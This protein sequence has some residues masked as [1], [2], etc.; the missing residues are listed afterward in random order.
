MIAPQAAATGTRSSSRIFGLDVVR[1]L[2]IGGVEWL[3]TRSYGLYLIHFPLVQ[4]LAAG[5]GSETWRLYL[6]LYFSQGFALFWP[7]WLIV[8]SNCRFS[9]AGRNNSRPPGPRLHVPRQQL[10]RRALLRLTQRL[11]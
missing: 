9:F 11:N 1:A 10:M 3:S 2:A 5:R 7:N 8:S 6:K 4:A